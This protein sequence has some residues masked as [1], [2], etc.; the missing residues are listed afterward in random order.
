MKRRTRFMAAVLAGVMSLSL[1][2]CG[3]SKTSG[4]SSGNSELAT[5]EAGTKA[6]SS[7]SSGTEAGGKTV[8]IAI[9]N[10]W[11]S[12]CPYFDAGNYTDIVSDQL[13]DRLW[14]TK[15]D[16]T[17]EPRLAESY[18]VADD[19]TSLYRKDHVQ[20]GDE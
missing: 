14:V 18:E 7:S 5:G 2:A 20:G 9:T 16:G 12:W 4:S 11:A 3:G 15:K 10:A 17:V 8:T 13:Y 1:A 6:A 19:H